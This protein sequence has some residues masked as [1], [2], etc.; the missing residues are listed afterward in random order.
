MAMFDNFD[1]HNY[2]IKW[3]EPEDNGLITAADFGLLEYEYGYHGTYDPYKTF[4]Y[5]WLMRK[6]GYI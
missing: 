1:Y 3:I 2:I 5:K 4:E 6:G